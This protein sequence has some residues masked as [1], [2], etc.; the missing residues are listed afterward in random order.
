[1]GATA[2]NTLLKHLKVRKM[3]VHWVSH[4]LSEEQKEHWVNWRQFMLEKFDHGKSKQE[5]DIATG[6][7]SWIY[8]FDPETECQSSR[9]DSF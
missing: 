8:E 9:L 1:M 5:Y 6:D 2:L 4:L 7:E 3:L